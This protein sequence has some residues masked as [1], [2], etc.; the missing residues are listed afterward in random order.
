MRMT[1]LRTAVAA[2][3]VLSTALP[4]A[5]APPGQSTVDSFR[6]PKLSSSLE[7]FGDNRQRLQ[8]VI[9]ERGS[10]SHPE[11]LR[12]HG[13]RPVAAFDWDNTVT[14]ND[15]TDLA[16]AWALKHDELLRPANW[17]D[18]SPWLTEKAVR[19][20]TE[21]CGTDVPVGRPLRTST[22]PACTDEIFSIREG[23]KLTS[24]ENAFSG[25]WN[26]RRTVPQYAWVA[27]LFA[28]HT[29]AEVNAIAR[30]SRAAALA[31][32]I[33]A[34]QKVGS[35]TI[36]AYAR[37]YPQMRDLIT[38]LKRA[39]FD[40]W[41]DSAGAAPI[42]EP[43]AAGVGIGGHRVIAIRNVL[44]R[45]GRI[46][47]TVKGCGGEPDGGGEDIPY[48]EGKRCWLNQEAFGVRGP[49][50]WQRQDFA[51]RPVIVGGDA[52]TDVSMVE[53]A[54]GAHV[55]LNRNQN[56]VLC[57][58]YDNADG[59]WVINPMFIEPLPR[60]EGSYP[61]ASTGY[62]NPNGSL[63]PVRRDDGTVIPD[64]L[65]TVHAR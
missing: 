14:K 44:D 59:R 54:T 2:V 43:W 5:G 6:C 55:V 30:A 25:D 61:C 10:C 20:L 21:A 52:N 29:E 24:G 48:V 37:Y 16:I 4:A 41:I 34:T 36:H 8:R 40:V 64:Q 18:T 39:G 1:F 27:Q 7:W 62:V 42:T 65:D 33:G 45:R 12:G 31:A 3:L 47:T 11:L 22:N 15:I 19:R 57:K 60:K 58:A 32:P 50:A 17:A 49:A 56:E 53:D 13:K 26:R 23:A 63:G 9:D 35:H 46:T 38:T 28:G 51:H